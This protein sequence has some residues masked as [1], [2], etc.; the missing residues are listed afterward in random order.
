MCSIICYNMCLD[1]TNLHDRN[2]FYLKF[3]EPYIKIF[4]KHGALL[5]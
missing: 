2:I 4:H 1:L 5:T 3:L